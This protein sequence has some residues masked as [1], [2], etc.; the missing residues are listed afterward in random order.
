ML[1]IRI[2]DCDGDSHPLRNERGMDG[3]PD[4]VRISAWFY[5]VRPS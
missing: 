3:A 5:R 2:I 4:L 1:S